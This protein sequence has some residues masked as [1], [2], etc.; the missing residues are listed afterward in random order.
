M[1]NSWLYVTDRHNIGIGGA[2]DIIVSQHLIMAL[3]VVLTQ[4][5]SELGH[6]AE[7]VSKLVEELRLLKHTSV[8]VGNVTFVGA[9]NVAQIGDYHIAQLN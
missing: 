8:P 2:L 7:W 3:D 1:D 9:Q 6:H 4:I 5:P